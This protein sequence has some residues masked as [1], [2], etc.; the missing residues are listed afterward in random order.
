MIG[1][2]RDFLRLVWHNGLFDGRELSF[3]DGVAREVAFVGAQSEADGYTLVG[4]EIVDHV[5]GSVMRGSVRIDARSSDFSH[6]DPAII[7]HVVLERDR[8]L[9]RGDEPL[10]TCVV[11]PHPKLVECRERMSIDC[12]QYFTGLESIEREALVLRLA[13]QRLERK[14]REIIKL[15][16]SV[17]EWTETFYVN[18]LRSFG[19]KEKKRDF[20]N[21]AR[22]LPYRHLNR[23]RHK[24]HLSEA[25][26]LGQAGFL[27]VKYP[28][29]YTAELQDEWR[30]FRSE[31]SLPAPILDW[32]TARTRPSSLPAIS[33]VRAATILARADDPMQSAL[34]AKSKADLYAF[35]DVQLPAYW[36]Y[37]SAPSRPSPGAG[38]RNFS[39][40]KLD[41]I[42]INCIAPFC[43]AYG[44]ERN[45]RRLVDL[46][47]ELLDE[48]VGEVNRY[49]TRFRG[50][51]LPAGTATDSQ[52]VVELCTSYCESG[53]CSACPI[54]AL[55]LHKTY[56]LIKL[57]LPRPGICLTTRQ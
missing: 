9:L 53:R 37:H 22:S 13:T 4:A 5:S 42:I 32:H 44:T 35:L 51:G 16:E 46:S 56:G 33:I 41:L 30:A 2:S 39:R 21:L 31:T 12:V 27:D 38:W 6:D 8:V 29:H 55:R 40:E 36:A 19:Y 10:L 18:F 52:A 14:G 28:D 3:S 23:H 34:T 48:M 26:L 45:D 50:G 15:H 49:T 11:K 25:L 57:S 24:D 17:G 7:L 1:D 20:E 47:V 43:W 54:G